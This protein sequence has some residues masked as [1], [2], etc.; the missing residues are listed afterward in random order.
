MDGNVFSWVGLHGSWKL[1]VVFART[2]DT[3]RHSAEMGFAVVPYDHRLPYLV[4]KTSPSSAGSFG[5]G[6]DAITCRSAPIVSSHSG[7][8]RSSPVFGRGKSTQPASKSS[9]SFGSVPLVQ[10]IFEGCV[11]SV[12]WPEVVELAPNL[13]GPAAGGVRE[14]REVRIGLFWLLVR[15]AGSD[16]YGR[17]GHGVTPL[18]PNRRCR[19]P[20][21]AIDRRDLDPPSVQVS[22]GVSTPRISRQP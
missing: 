19:A 18:Q 1:L 2:L 5:T 9:A 13:L 15:F 4:I 8:R 12:P 6:R 14:Q 3:N 17:L 22:R 10:V 20:A 16:G 7:Q 11:G 21:T